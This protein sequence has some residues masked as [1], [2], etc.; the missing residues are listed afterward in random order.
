MNIAAW[1]YPSLK[2]Q[3]TDIFPYRLNFPELSCHATQA[4]LPTEEAKPTRPL[5]SPYSRTCHTSKN[6][7]T[8]PA[9]KAELDFA[10]IINPSKPDNLTDTSTTR[11]QMPTR[12]KIPPT[13]RPQTNGPPTLTRAT[14]PFP[15]TSHHVFRFHQRRRPSPSQ[16]PSQTRAPL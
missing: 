11:H 10:E 13:Q 16:T 7:T 1:C 5:S 8:H 3:E 2:P 4:V 15:V 9:P 12:T 14:V 6:L